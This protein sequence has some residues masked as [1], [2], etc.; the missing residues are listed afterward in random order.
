MPIGPQMLKDVEE[1]MLAGLAT[2]RDPGTP[3]QN[4]MDQHSLT[5]FPSQ[6]WCKM[7]VEFR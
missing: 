7:C 2:L 6:F 3:D 4:V 5:H 1:P